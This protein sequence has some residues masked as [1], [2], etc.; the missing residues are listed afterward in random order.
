MKTASQSNDVVFGDDFIRKQC[1]TDNPDDV[2]HFEYD[3]SPGFEKINQIT[4][5]TYFLRITDLSLVGH[6]FKDL[7]PF[8][9]LVNLQR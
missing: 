9:S 7:I 5:F 4:P 2:I 6:S 3:Y 8:Q 1:K